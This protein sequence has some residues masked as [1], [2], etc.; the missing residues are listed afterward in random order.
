MGAQLEVRKVAAVIHLGV[1]RHFGSQYLPAGANRQELV[2]HLNFHHEIHKMAFGPDFPGLVHVL[3]GRRKNQHQPPLTEHFQYD[4]HVIPTTYVD[5]A[6]E[7]INSHQYSVT[8]YVKNID[9]TA[10][11]QELVA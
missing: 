5:E 7:E 1:G 2:T 4:L 11:H 8:E 3:D 9:E 10:R 6:G